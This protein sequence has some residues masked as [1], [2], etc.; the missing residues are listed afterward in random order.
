MKYATVG[1][2]AV[3]DGRREDSK[4]CPPNSTMKGPSVLRRHVI[5]APEG[6]LFGFR[7]SQE[8]PEAWLVL[9]DGSQRCSGL[10]VFLQGC[11][12]DAAKEARIH[13]RWA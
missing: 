6:A 9:N 12:P 13:F 1:W 3:P 8:Y 4:L 10:L 2:V 7:T 11:L 5:P